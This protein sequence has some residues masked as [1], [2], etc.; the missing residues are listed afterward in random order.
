MK[1]GL[2]ALC[3]VF[4]LG[5]AAAGLLYRELRRPY[6]GYSGSLVIEIGPGT[7]TPEVAQSLV[8]RGVLAHRIPFL[9]LH[10]LDLLRHRSVKAD[11]KST[12]LNSSHVTTSRM[13]SSA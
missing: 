9:I 6:R 12:R 7:R 3:L 8:S 13:P 1:K 2:L 5:L 10:A 4:I 11:R